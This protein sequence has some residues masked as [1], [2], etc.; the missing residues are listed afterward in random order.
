MWIKTILTLC[1]KKEHLPR[2]I[3]L[4]CS[5]IKFDSTM[6]EKKPKTFKKL[7]YIQLHYIISN[8][9]HVWEFSPNIFF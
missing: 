1:V 2:Q 6:R 5:N 9:I 4:Q 7:S 3:Q 8:K